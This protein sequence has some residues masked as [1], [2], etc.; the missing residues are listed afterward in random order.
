[1]SVI[2]GL[3]QAKD[4]A[5]LANVRRSMSCFGGGRLQVSGPRM[6]AAIDSHERL[7]RPLRD[8]RYNNV[9]M[10]CNRTN[11]DIPE[12]FVPVAIEV[13][14]SQNLAY[15]E[16]PKNAFY[17]FG[18]EDGSLPPQ[19]LRKCHHVVMIPTL[20]CLNLAVTVSIVLYD[21]MQKT[22]TRMNS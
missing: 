11:F 19:V 3:H 14:G 17:I 10:D 7:P 12:G 13:G 15:F 18:P 8:R 16:H 6:V 2:V 21:R 5:N 4:P 1:M 9:T 20:Q 22:W